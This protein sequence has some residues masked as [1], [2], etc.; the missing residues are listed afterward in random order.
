MSIVRRRRHLTHA[1]PPG[2][3]E[4]RAQAAG[5]EIRDV[6]VRYGAFA[7]GP[8]SA[9][10]DRGEIVS[11]LGPNGS[12]KSSLMRAILG[13]QRTDTG[14]A[15]W[16][17]VSLAGRPTRVLVRVGS[18]TDSPDDVIPE[19]TP[20]EYWELCAVAYSRH[21]G[22]AERDIG[23][24]LRRAGDLAAR[25]EVAPPRRS[26]AGFSLGMRRKT[27]L[28]ASMLHA[29]ELLVLDEPLVGLDFMSINAL[30]AV[31]AAE[32]ERGALVFMAGHDMGLAARL[33]DRALVL[34]MGRLV[35]DVRT[36]L[37]AA[38]ETLEDVVLAA[39]RRAR[40][41]SAQR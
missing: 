17:G 14:A 32:R 3:G 9:V 39:I 27:Q 33:A 4:R 15:A 30:E 25:L 16:N 2:P 1:A 19:L 38:D 29:P 18:L 37:I 28:V 21:S 10:L 7:L 34:H 13:L 31:L 12:G 26:I 22:D 41:T 35:L 23:E 20:R 40:G 36:A 24:M 8:L 6:E 11:L 5:L